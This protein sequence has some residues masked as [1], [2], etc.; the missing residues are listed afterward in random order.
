MRKKLPMPNEFE[1][2]NW[3]EL[4]ALDNYANE[5]ELLEWQLEFINEL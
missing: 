3:G 2:E 4:E 1:I 5:F